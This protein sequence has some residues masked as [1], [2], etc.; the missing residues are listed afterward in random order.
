MHVAQ[1]CPAVAAAPMRIEV[2]AS[3]HTPC[4]PFRRS[5]RHS[6]TPFCLLS[7]LLLKRL[8]A[9]E[10]LELYDLLVF[11]PERRI[12]GSS[13]APPAAVYAH[14]WPSVVV[15][16]QEVQESTVPWQSSPSCRSCHFSSLSSLRSRDPS[17]ERCSLASWLQPRSTHVSPIGRDLMNSAKVS[18]SR[19]PLCLRLLLVRGASSSQQSNACDA[20]GAEGPNVLGAVRDGVCT[21]CLRNGK[22]SRSK[23]S[24]ST[25]L[26]VAKYSTLIL[27]R[28]RNCRASRLQA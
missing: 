12:L 2:T 1:P 21:G 24:Y 18:I 4:W 16:F 28:C 3:H 20:S 26:R 17:S 11:L 22:S 9:H 25:C 27:I 7:C 23:F 5:L 15:L 19:G 10:V 6:C 14:M 13:Q 8:P